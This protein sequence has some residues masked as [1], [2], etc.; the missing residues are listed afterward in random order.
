MQLNVTVADLS[1]PEQLA[2]VG[3]EPP[4]PGRTGWPAYQGVGEALAADGWAGLVAPSAA[5]PAGLVVCLFR[6]EVRPVP[7]VR[8]LPPPQHV[9]RAPAPPRGMT[10]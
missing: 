5:R 8:L 7:G 2:A 10:T 6:H 4:R 9:D 1:T 3:L